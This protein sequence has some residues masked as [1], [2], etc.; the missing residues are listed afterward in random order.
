MPSKNRPDF[1]GIALREIRIVTDSVLQRGTVKR[2]E[3]ALIATLPFLGV[4]PPR[5][6]FDH[7]PLTLNGCPEQPGSV[8][9][10]VEAWRRAYSGKWDLK[11]LDA[12]APKDEKARSRRAFFAY[13]IHAT[14]RCVEAA[15]AKNP[16]PAENKPLTPERLC[17]LFQDR[18][19]KLEAKRPLP[20]AI[21]NAAMWIFQ[22]LA[23]EMKKGRIRPSRLDELLDEVWGVIRDDELTKEDA[24]R[25][26]MKLKDQEVPK[27]RPSLKVVRSDVHAA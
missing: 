7:M 8:E 13:I 2:S 10:Y 12:R 3:M 6:N 25:L 16:S 5:P 23:T 11:E 4:D 9:M 19:N 14:A 17:K 22:L 27:L 20:V 15:L 26:I 1:R 24:E 21:E 18:I